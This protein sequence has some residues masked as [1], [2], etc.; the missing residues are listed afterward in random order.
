MTSSPTL[1]GSNAERSRTRNRIAVLGKIHHSGE[2]GRAELARGLDLSVQAVSNIIADLLGDGMLVEKGARSAGRGL[3][4]VQYGINPTGGYALGI[5]IRPTVIYAA[6]LDLLGDTVFTHRSTIGDAQPDAVVPEVTR[7]RDL[8]LQAVPKARDRLLGAGIVMPG[9]FGATGL[10]GRETDLPNWQN[11]NPTELFQTALNLPIEVSNDANAA[12]M[13]ER[14]SGC[15][16]GLGSFGYLYFG[17]GLGLGLVSQ[18]HLIRGAFG[19]AG[20]IGHIP[21]PT[22][23]GSAPLETRLSRMSVQHHLELAG[24]EDVDFEALE[25]LYVQSNPDLMTWL[26]SATDAL[27]HATQIIENIFDPR[28]II[29]GGAMP[30]TILQHL[31]NNVV[32]NSASVSQRNDNSQPRLQCGASGR[33]VATLGAAA[34]I[35]N[36]RLTPNAAD[37]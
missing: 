29:L 28:T 6:M 4:A 34:L 18:G 32:L 36:R 1:K 13:S 19:N 17:S 37:L 25:A 24:Q 15:A 7:L 33:L 23:R 31:V 9:P 11:V 30:E 26:R 21:V 5:E 12:A 35:L 14:I 22:P 16:Q 27:G 10:S 8:A 20:E 3:P 2:L